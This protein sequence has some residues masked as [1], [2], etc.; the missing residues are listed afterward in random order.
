MGKIFGSVRPV[1][2]SLLTTLHASTHW[3]TI[4]YMGFPLY[5]DAKL[6]PLVL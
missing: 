1:L 5:M 6:E 2:S 3:I 4:V